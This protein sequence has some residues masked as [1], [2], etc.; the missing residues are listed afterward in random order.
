[1]VEEPVQ[2]DGEKAYEESRQA[3]VA[4]F[5]REYF[6]RIAVREGLM[7][8]LEFWNRDMSILTIPHRPIP[9]AGQRPAVQWSLN[10]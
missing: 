4:A 1:M 2:L 9:G 10:R 6:Q 3:E 8:Q 5:N 7:I